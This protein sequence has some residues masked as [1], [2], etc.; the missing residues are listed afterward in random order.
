MSNRLHAD[1]PDGL[2]VAALHT[3]RLPLSALRA[4]LDE[5]SA[6]ANWSL[7]PDGVIGRALMMPA[8][9]VFTVPLEL[10]NEV[11]FSARAMLLPHDWRDGRDAVRVSVALID[12]ARQRSE[13]WSARLRATD[14]ATPRGQRFKCQL[15]SWTKALQLSVDVCAPLRLRSVARAIWLEP[16][17]L[18]PHAPP[19]RARPPR[20]QSTQSPRAFSRPLIS[21][22]TPV[23][24]PPPHMLEEAIASVLKQTFA[25]WELCLVDD[26]SI[27]QTHTFKLK[28]TNTIAMSGKRLTRHQKA[29][30]AQFSSLAAAP[31]AIGPAAAAG[32]RVRRRG[33]RRRLLL[34]ECPRSPPSPKSVFLPSLSLSLSHLFHF[35]SQFFHGFLIPTKS[36][37]NLTLFHFNFLN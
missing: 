15:P 4:R 12:A 23:H 10:A 25:N 7:N 11:S 5:E 32:E 1:V 33:P 37:F 17:V 16:T 6:A 34:R 20:A 26:G 9:S 36:I 2:D 21:V 22:L 30:V 8:G 13:I 24:D 19:V 35:A 18:D 29:L 28:H 31:G 27:S 14:L 3:P